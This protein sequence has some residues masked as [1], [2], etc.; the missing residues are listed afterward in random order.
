MTALLG[1][2]SF[3]PQCCFIFFH[4]F[5]R[6]TA[7]F[8][9]LLFFLGHSH[10]LCLSSPHQK[11][12][13][14]SL[15]TSCLLISLTPHCITRLFNTSNL[16]PTTVSFFYS[17]LLLHFWARCPNLPHF[18]QILPSLPSNSVLNLA[19]AR[20]WLSVLLMSLWY[21]SKDIVYCT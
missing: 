8:L 10:F 11:H 20:L 7:S 5:H 9:F 4:T 19:R 15:T 16:F 14:T 17:S 1:G 13:T 18:L 2:S 12:F 6:G 21:T 3:T